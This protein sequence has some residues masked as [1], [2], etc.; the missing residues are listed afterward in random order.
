MSCWAATCAL[1]GL[2]LYTEDV[3]MGLV[4]LETGAKSKTGGPSCIHDDRLRMVTPPLWGRYDTYGCVEV[5]DNIEARHALEW[6]TKVIPSAK[7][8]KDA[9]EILSREEVSYEE[10]HFGV[11]N[12]Y[13]TMVR[14]DVW[15][16]MVRQA[17]ELKPLLRGV[18]QNAARKMRADEKLSEH[19]QDVLMSM[20]DSFFGFKMPKTLV[21]LSYDKRRRYEPDLK[22]AT[23]EDIRVAVDVFY[24]QI[25]MKELHMEWGTGTGF[26]MQ[27][28]NHQIRKTWFRAM[29]ALCKKVER[30]R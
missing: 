8:L 27:V 29:S 30:W 25:L 4:I 14:E 12:V 7:S 10:P 28:S 19:E 2:T 22:S 1:S 18:F 24:V 6:V 9:Q 20:K 16:A 26:G 15:N 23:D 3:R 13:Y 5:E 11:R 21:V 17:E